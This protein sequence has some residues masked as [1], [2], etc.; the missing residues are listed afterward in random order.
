[1]DAKLPPLASEAGPEARRRPCIS[2][3][4]AART[5]AQRII[6]ESNGAPNS[7]HEIQAKGTHRHGATAPG[8]ALERGLARRLTSGRA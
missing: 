2:A 6:H 7:A 8:E 1:M 3:G 5:P 4:R